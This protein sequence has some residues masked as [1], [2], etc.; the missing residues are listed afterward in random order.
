MAQKEGIT[1][2]RSKDKK[3]GKYTPPEAGNVLPHT[4]QGSKF[5]NFA[6]SFRPLFTK[7]L[8]NPHA[9]LLVKKMPFRW[10]YTH[11]KLDQTQ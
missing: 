9:K 6:R 2:L 8:A 4:V 5:E 11:L 10:P 1:V 7:Y 3:A